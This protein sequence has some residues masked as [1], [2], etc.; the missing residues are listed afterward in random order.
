M[1]LEAGD[2]LEVSKIVRDEIDACPKAK[3]QAKDIKHLQAATESLEEVDR[4]IFEKMETQNVTLINKINTQ[5]ET[6]IDKLGTM[7]TTLYKQMDGLKSLLLTAL[8][9]AGASLIVG[10][11]IF[12]LNF[13]KRGGA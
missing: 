6:L 13:N 10:V 5:N 7:G 2:K 4:R 8:L 11:V 3:E 9:G 12:L 1:T